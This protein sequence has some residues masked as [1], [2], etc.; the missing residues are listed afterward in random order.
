MIGQGDR[1]GGGQGESS[2]G[3]VRGRGGGTGRRGRSRGQVRGRGLEEREAVG[4]QFRGR[5]SVGCTT[6]ST[7]NFSLECM[8]AF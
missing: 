6:L 5:V 8:A 4:A 2:R 1:S 3:Q 7:P